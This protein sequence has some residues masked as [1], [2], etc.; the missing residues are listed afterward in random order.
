MGTG[1]GA[2]TAKRAPVQ[3][4][5]DE[6]V[7]PILA[8]FSMG[9]GALAGAAFGIGG[10]FIATVFPAMLRTALPGMT[11]VVFL[12]LWTGAMTLPLLAFARVFRNG[13]SLGGRAYATCGIAVLAISFAGELTG[14]ISIYPW[15]ARTYVVPGTYD[16]RR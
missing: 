15:H 5:A 3:F 8:A 14:T 2:R 12:A 4:G 11:D 13:K 16:V 9:F 7:H 10:F 6:P 1:T